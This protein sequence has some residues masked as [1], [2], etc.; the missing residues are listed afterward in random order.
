MEKYV[1]P[2]RSGCR[3]RLRSARASHRSARRKRATFT[4]AIKRSR[5]I[6]S[7]TTSSAALC[8]EP[9]KRLDRSIPLETSVSVRRSSATNSRWRHRV[10]ASSS[11]VELDRAN[12]ND[13]AR[14]TLYSIRIELYRNN[15]IRIIRNFRYF[16]SVLFF[17]M[18]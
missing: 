16:V 9:T 6:A 7:R 14:E 1:G 11:F 18:I 13:S 3:R 2:R 17:G 15:K 12:L 8:R 4:F 5:V 10:V